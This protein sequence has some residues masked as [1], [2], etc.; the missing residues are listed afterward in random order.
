[1][2][3]QHHYRRARFLPSS[4]LLCRSKNP[5]WAGGEGEDLNWL[6]DWSFDNRLDCIF[7]YLKKWLEQPRDLG[8]ICN[9]RT[10]NIQESLSVLNCKK[11]KGISFFCIPFW[12][13]KWQ[14]H[15]SVLAWR[16]P[17]MGEPGG[18]PSMGLQRVRHDWSDLAAAAAASETIRINK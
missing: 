1:M 11:I 9:P 10:I 15:Y 7:Y 3:L 5:A 13:R 4:L 6:K 16:I 12:R 8:S 17:E 18:L 2:T 14:T